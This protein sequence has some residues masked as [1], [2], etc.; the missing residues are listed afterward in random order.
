MVGEVKHRISVLELCVE[1]RN[2]EGDKLLST[3]ECV[4]A[5]FQPN[6]EKHHTEKQRH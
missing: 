2:G 5:D 3:G 1:R 6:E 4:C